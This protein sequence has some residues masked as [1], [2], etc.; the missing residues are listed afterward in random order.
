MAV[1]K[2]DVCK[3]TL[4]MDAGG[5]TATCTICGVQYPRERLQEKIQEIRGGVKI[6][7]PIDVRGTVEVIGVETK[8]SL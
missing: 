8:K 2:C 3:G 6:E 5:K 4:K 1:L 7:S